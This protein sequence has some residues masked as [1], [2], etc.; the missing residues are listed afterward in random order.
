MSNRSGKVRVAIL[1]ATG[2]VGQ[3]F[4]QLLAEHPLFEIA[5]LAASEKSVDK[6]YKSAVNWLLSTSLPSH[7]AEMKIS[8]CLPDLPCDL[9]F[10]GLDSSVAGE[11]ELQFAQAGYMV[12][13]NARNHRMHSDVPLM[14]AEVNPDHLCLAEKQS[15]AGKIITNP[16]CSAIGLT[17]ALK[18]LLD[19]FGLESVHV[20]TLQAIS[21]AGYPGVA[22]LDIFDNVV[23]FISQE[24][25]KIEIETL[26]ILG[27]S[28][29]NQI[30]MGKFKV[31]AQCNR[32]PVTDGHLEC[33]SV[34]LKSAASKQD[35]IR[36][37]NEFEGIPQQLRLPLAPL[38]PTRYFYEET[39]PQP[40][41]HRHLDKSMSVAI[42]RLRECS[43]FDYKFAILSHN[44]IRG[45]AG[46]AI[47]NAE[48]QV[49][50]LHNSKL[51]SHSSS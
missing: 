8:P 26:K 24:E 11:I 32:V 5:A 42:G 39:Y 37:W 18:P 4:I 43:I 23:P 13:S 1:G 12:H 38:H 15:T 48:L 49:S 41:L 40:K 45:A 29:N 35:L 36:A 46:G 22:S 9:V 7:I 28:V 44:T 47:L 34:K 31:S 6:P 10:S 16:N 33:I 21:G 50:T 2:S 25:E 19:R 51:N 14:V 20:V 27:K 17:L 30:E 3:R